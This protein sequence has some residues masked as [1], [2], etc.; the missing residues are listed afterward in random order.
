MLKQ[1]SVQQLRSGELTR[2]K[3]YIVISMCFYP[4]G[5]KK[6]LK[7]E[8]RNDLAPTP[9]LLKDF[10]HFQALE[11]HEAGF[12]KSHYEERFQLS[13]RAFEYFKWL[14]QSSVEKDVYL[15]CQCELG[16]RCHREILLLIAQ[17]EFGT[18]IDKVFSSYPV[19]L[20]RLKTK[21]PTGQLRNPD[22]PC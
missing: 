13:R 14:C 3:G 1:A 10:K 4:R 20:E 2:E 15:V 6:E 5:L 22:P 16:E 17:K 18:E 9:E 8:F 12:E 21:L 11:G 19:F 7:D